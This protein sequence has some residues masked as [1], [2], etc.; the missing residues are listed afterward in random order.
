MN[1]IILKGRLT[2]DIDLKYTQTNNT[3]LASG[4]IAVD[5]RFAQEGQ[6]NVDFFNIKAFGKQAEV[7]S[8]YFKKGSEILIQGHI[9]NNSW[10]GQDGTKKTSTDVIIDNFDFCGKKENNETQNDIATPE[11]TVVDNDPNSLPF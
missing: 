6:T 10:E 9:Q 1:S 2:R 5:R 3:A 4:S 11:V 7:I 8:K